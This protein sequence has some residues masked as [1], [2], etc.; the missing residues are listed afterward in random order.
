MA[1]MNDEDPTQSEGDISS[2]ARFAAVLETMVDAV[3][4]IDERGTVLSGNSAVKRIFGYDPDD[5]V[6]RNVSMLM[7]AAFSVEHTSYIQKYLET[8]EATIIGIGRETTGL[9]SDGTEFPIDL[10]ISESHV[11]PRRLFT[12]IVR[13]ISERKQ[14]EAKIQSLNLEL[15]NRVQERTQQ[16]ESANASLSREASD[17]TALAEITRI[18]TS[19]PRVGDVFGNFAEQVE[20]LV[21]F[22]RMSICAFNSD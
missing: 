7:P 22:D 11:G 21:P 10:A 1:S 4:T 3:I 20:N 8:G 2:E 15:E 6:G 18:I 13:D 5:M 12:G 9:R 19:S 17:R 14:A 16:L